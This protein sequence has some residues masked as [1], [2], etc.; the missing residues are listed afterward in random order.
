MAK[1]VIVS[2]G[3]AKNFANKGTINDGR[4]GDADADRKKICCK[5][6]KS[7]VVVENENA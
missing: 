3:K 7:F 2:E 4:N 6:L 1:N 5:A